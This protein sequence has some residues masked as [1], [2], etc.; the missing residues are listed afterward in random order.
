M[1]SKLKAESISRFNDEESN[2]CIQL[3]EKEKEYILS[4]DAPGLN[5]RDFDISIEKNML[6]IRSTKDTSHID[7]II[8]KNNHCEYQ[9]H[10]LKRTF[11]LP[12]DAEV[13]AAEA[14]WADGT[15]FVRFPK[16]KEPF[17]QPLLKVPV[18]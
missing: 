16:H 6:I 3:E 4:M 17:L 9:L 11:A 10:Q 13:N 18:S 12:S 7:R 15:L 5:K 8:R 1:E 2:T 14:D